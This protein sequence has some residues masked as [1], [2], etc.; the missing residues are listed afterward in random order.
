[1]ENVFSENRENQIFIKVYLDEKIS[2]VLSKTLW[3]NWIRS[4]D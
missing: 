4:Y 2:S 3:Y 1:M